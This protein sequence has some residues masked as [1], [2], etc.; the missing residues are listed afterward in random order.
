MEVNSFDNIAQPSQLDMKN[1]LISKLKQYKNVDIKTKEETN[2][3]GIY[4]S[5]TAHIKLSD[6]GNGLFHSATLKTV[7]Y[8]KRTVNI[9]CVF[10]DNKNLHHD[11]K[12][13]RDSV[14]Q[15]FRDIAPDT[16]TS[17]SLEDFNDQSDEPHLRIIASTIKGSSLIYVYKRLMDF[18]KII[19]DKYGNLIINSPESETKPISIPKP[20][21]EFT[22][23]SALASTPPPAPAPAPKLSTLTLPVKPTSI[24]EVPTLEIV[25][26]VSESKYV[27]DSKPSR[28]VPI[29]KNNNNIRYEKNTTISKYN[30][31]ENTIKELEEE[32]KRLQIILDTIRL[33]KQTHIDCLKVNSEV[34]PDT[35][36][37]TN[38]DTK[39]ETKGDAK[40]DAKGDTKENVSS[41][42]SFASK[43]KQS[44][45]K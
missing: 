43:V 28:P 29:P 37:D 25:T 17:I 22:L 26:Q 4:Y 23:A 7:T 9:K 13:D 36:L 33:L 41:Q 15:C 2:N 18:V 1:I 14:F 34:N 8:N 45:K 32:E 21:L 35:N 10:T 19:N 44:L 31:S 40:P 3:V 6:F 16:I 24:Q 39:Q 5:I 38:L 11:M 42:I 30:L 27:S 12:I 20:A